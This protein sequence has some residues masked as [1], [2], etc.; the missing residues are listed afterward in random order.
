MLFMWLFYWT[1][2]DFFSQEKIFVF[3]IYTLNFLNPLLMFVCY[4]SSCTNQAKHT[5]F[6]Q[7][8][9]ENQQQRRAALTAN[10]QQQ[11]S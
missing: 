7:M 3:D 5:V 6:P 10:Y 9:F 8:I 11:E 2:G 1:A 4:D